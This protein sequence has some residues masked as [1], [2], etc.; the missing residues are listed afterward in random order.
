[1]A[2][3]ACAE[4]TAVVDRQPHS[5]DYAPQAPTVPRIWGMSRPVW[6]LIAGFCGFL[7]FVVWAVPVAGEPAMSRGAM[8]FV[9]SMTT[10]GAVALVTALRLR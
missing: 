9:A 5:L 2:G 7:A 10:A 3:G 4:G 1:M 8:A 6:L